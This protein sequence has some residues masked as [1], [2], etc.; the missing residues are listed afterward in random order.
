MQRTYEELYPGGNF[1]HLTQTVEQYCSSDTPIWWVEGETSEDAPL[2]SGRAI[3]HPIGCLWLGNAIAQ[4]TGER[5]AYIFLLYVLPEHRRQGIGA[6]LVR[7]AEDWAKARGDRQIGLQV[8]E[9]NQSA[10][11]LYR[12]LGYQTESLGMVKPL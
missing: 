5:Y 1:S 4:T 2:P 12:A 8:F 6:A 9:T 7:C 11:N 10:L 3:R